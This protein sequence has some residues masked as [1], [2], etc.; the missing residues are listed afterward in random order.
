MVSIYPMIKSLE[1]LNIFPPLQE[2]IFLQSLLMIIKMAHK[3]FIV[4]FFLSS[5]ISSHLIP[6]IH[7]FWRKKGKLSLCLSITILK[8]V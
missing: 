2:K 6:Q 8:W 7:C 1:T 5:Q 4:F 3:K